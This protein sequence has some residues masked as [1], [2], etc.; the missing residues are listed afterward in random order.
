VAAPLS[1]LAGALEERAFVVTCELNP[2]RGTDLEPLLATATRLAAHVDAINLTD[3]HASLMAMSPLAPAR[4]MIERGIEP[5][6][7]ITARDRNRIGLQGD[8]LAAYALGVRNL[9]I[10]R[11]D[12][13]AN[14]DHP[15]ATPVFDLDSAALLAAARGLEQGHDLSGQPLRG[16]PRFCLGAVADPG[17]PDLAAEVARLA[18]KVA[19]GAR[20]VQTQAIYDPAAFERFARA[21]EDLDAALLAGILPLKS[22]RMAEWIHAHVPGL[23]VPEALVAE[24]A[25]AADRRATAVARAARI[26]AEVRPMCHGVHIMAL[27]WEREIPGILARAGIG[28]PARGGGGAGRG[29]K[30]G[31]ARGP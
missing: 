20:F 10:M 31:P 11:G 5:I 14:G 13:P 1:R 29:K 3:S 8:L 12:P 16:R 27:G 2:P 30:E 26:L 22:A 28:I 23:E 21:A 6:V 9:V 24:I 19:A 17:A 18:E 4:R 7:Q 15:Q 25:A